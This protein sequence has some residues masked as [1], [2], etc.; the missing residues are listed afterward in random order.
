MDTQ[1]LK[2]LPRVKRTCAECGSVKSYKNPVAR[3]FECGRIFCF[4]HIWGGQAKAGM[5]QGEP[6][7]DICEYCKGKYNYK[8][9]GTQNKTA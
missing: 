1:R 2:M 6:G 4:D 5:K 7:R 9:I 3:C 8:T